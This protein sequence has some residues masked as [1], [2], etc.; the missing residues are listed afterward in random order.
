MR[1]VDVL[2]CTIRVT[3]E[4]DEED[5]DGEEELLREEDDDEDG[6]EKVVRGFSGDDGD[7]ATCSNLLFSA[8]TI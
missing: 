3:E 1:L 2:G 5:E 4:D 8:N 7:G 6:E